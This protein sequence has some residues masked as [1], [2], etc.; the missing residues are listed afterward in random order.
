MLLC[1][2][3][4]EEVES[5]NFRKILRLS[6]RQAEALR[7]HGIQTDVTAQLDASM[8]KD[9]ALGKHTDA[10]CVSGRLSSEPRSVAY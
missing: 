9:S 6:V 5:G 7:D 3:S 2:S 4:Q 10:G 8:Q 1:A